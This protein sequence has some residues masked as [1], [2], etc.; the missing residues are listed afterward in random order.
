M[1]RSDI[2]NR[3]TYWQNTRMVAVDAIRTYGHAA[4]EAHTSTY[5]A[6]TERPSRGDVR[7]QCEPGTCLLRGE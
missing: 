6:A 4:A 7:C 3:L 2:Q 1:A 5:C